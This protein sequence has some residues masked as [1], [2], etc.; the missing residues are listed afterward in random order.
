LADMAR[1]LGG[2][3]SG[4]QVCCPGPGHSPEDRSLSVKLNA[5]GDG[6]VVH[7]FSGDDIIVCKD[8]VRAK[9]GMAPFTPKRKSNGSARKAIAATYNYVDECGELLY[10]VVRYEPKDF[11]QRRPDGNGGWTWKLDERRVVYRWPELLKFPDG[12]V[13][14]TEGEKDA[15][16]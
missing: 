14:V 7:S 13:F 2:E 6:I 12:T 10:Q 16:R 11:R 5:S 3:I 1:Q 8:H 9:L 15:D 4:G